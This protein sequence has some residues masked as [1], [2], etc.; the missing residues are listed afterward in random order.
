MII[1]NIVTIFPKQ[2]ESFTTEGIYR[3]AQEKEKTEI[4]IHNLRKW[5]EGKHNKVDDRP[6]GGGPGMVLMIEPIYKAIKY[7]KDKHP[8]Y[9]N[10]VLLTTPKGTR[11][12]QKIL[13]E[14]TLPKENI[15]Y[16]IICGHYE[17][18][19]QRIHDHL[20]DMDISIG[21]FVISGGELPALIL[22][23]GII[24]LI[25]EV[26]GNK[27]SFKK[28]SFYKSKESLDYPQYTRPAKFENWEVPNILLSG[29]HKNIEDWRKK[30]QDNK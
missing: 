11:L 17:G 4:K 5:G 8:Q 19:D 25:P 7:I 22:I 3:I 6:F 16:I 29:H 18:F 26:L 1:F 24:R 30:K 27:E 14:L 23:D 15:N 21:N 10:K 2:I 28:D 9:T 20:S 12:N 13:K